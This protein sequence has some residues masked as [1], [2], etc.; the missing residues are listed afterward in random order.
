MAKLPQPVIDLFNEPFVPKAM[1][2]C[3]AEGTLNVV[4]KGT[5][6]AVDDETLA[7]GDVMGGKTNANVAA[8]KKVAVTAFK[9]QLPPVGFQ[10]KGTFQEFQT[11]GALFDKM[12]KEVK[13]RLSLDIQSVGII[14]VDEVYSVA[15]PN[16]GKK[17]A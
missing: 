2:T 11:A 4:P 1:A 10:V 6:V 8:T 15:P 3:D 16:A 14:K 9:M 17:I 5:V 7:W 13:E 12:A